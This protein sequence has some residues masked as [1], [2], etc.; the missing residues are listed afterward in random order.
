MSDKTEASN[1]TTVEL[2]LEQSRHLVMNGK[3]P[4]VQALGALTAAA[5]LINDLD[6]SAFRNDAS[7]QQ[8]TALYLRL[9]DNISNAIEDGVRRSDFDDLF[10]GDADEGGEL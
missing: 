6:F 1:T 2:T 10:G 5:L 8:Y 4:Q 7:C 9:L 3:N